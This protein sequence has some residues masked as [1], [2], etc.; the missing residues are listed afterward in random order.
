MGRHNNFHNYPARLAAGIYLLD[1]GMGK[2]SS[3]ANA[4]EYL[5][6]MATGAYP[7]LEEF[8]SQ[9]FSRYFAIGEIMLAA[10]L[11]IPFFPEG[12]VGIGLTI[13]SSSLFGLYFRLPEMRLAGSIRPTP[14]GTSLAKNVW[15]LGI[16]ISLALTSYRTTKDK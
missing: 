14:K 2:L 5:H 4:L 6:Q 1:S 13:F 3:D 16:G 11:L 8:D 10:C 15:L 9:K 12:I 7:F